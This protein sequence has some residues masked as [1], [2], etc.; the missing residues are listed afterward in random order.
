MLTSAGKNALRHGCV[1]FAA[2]HALQLRCNCYRAKRTEDTLQQIRFASVVLIF[3]LSGPS[4]GPLA[5]R[6]QVLS[7]G[8]RRELFVD[9]LVIEQLTGGARLQLHHPRPAGVAVRFDKP[10]EGKYAAYATVLK[11]GD[12]YRMYY[13]GHPG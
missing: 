9:R 3:L 7:I 1:C 4:F 6:A 10:W 2:R 5:S 12:K 8:S 13:R 11:D